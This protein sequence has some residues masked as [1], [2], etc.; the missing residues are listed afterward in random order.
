M[1]LGETVQAEH[2]YNIDQTEFTIQNCCLLRGVRVYVPQELRKQVLNELHTA[3]F[4]I[5]RMKSLARSYC[6]WPGLDKD[7]DNVT[8]NCL[9]CQQTR[10]NPKKVTTHVWEAAKTPFERVH[11]DFAGPFMGIYFFILIDAFTKWPEINIIPNITTAITIEKCREI[12]ARFGVPEV[13]VSD[14]GAQFTS[15]EFQHF[16]EMIGIIHKRS[17]PYHPATNGQAER[18]VQTFKNTLKTINCDRADLKKVLN[19]I[20][21]NYRRTPHATTGESPSAL[22]LNRQIR[23]RLDSMIPKKHI[24]NHST[25]RNYIQV[26]N[27]HLNDRVSVRDYTS[28][29]KYQFG[30]II[31]VLGKLHYMVKLDDGRIWKRHIDQIHRMGSDIKPAMP[32]PIPYH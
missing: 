25:H 23:T 17:A 5:T 6:W 11:V 26:R 12:F 30:V 3:H 2:R 32:D 13:L 4:G 21:L 31:E 19:N 10:P 16:M 8:K 15:N 14:N 27:V 18:N 29:E 7:I 9:Q 20:L 22:M 24:E 28:G 1:R